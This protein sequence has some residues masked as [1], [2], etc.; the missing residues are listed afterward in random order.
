MSPF[1]PALTPGV[2][3]VSIWRVLVILFHIIL[4]CAHCQALSAASS[5]VCSTTFPTAILTSIGKSQLAVLDGA[6]W[7]SV[8]T[9]LRGESSTSTGASRNITTTK[10]G[11]MRVVTGRDGENRRV[12]AMQC[13]GDDGSD[14]TNINNLL[15]YEDS[16]A[17]LPEKVSDSDAIAT[18]IACLSSVHCA[19]PRVEK[20]GGGNDSIAAGRAVVLGSSDVA[21]FAAEGLASLGIDVVLVNPK[22]TANVKANVGRCEWIYPLGS[23]QHQFLVYSMCADSYFL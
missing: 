23:L 16:I 6:E 4:S 7:N 20:V 5:R 22:G 3:V 11:Y 8:Q 2:T 17:V 15:V 18:F 13:D 21:C 10:Y 14:G 9:I 12:V 1:L 19:I